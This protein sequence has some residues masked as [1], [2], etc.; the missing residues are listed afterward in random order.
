MQKNPRIIAQKLLNLYRQ[1]HVI[2]GGISA[3]NPIFIDEADDTVIEHLDALPGGRFLVAHIENL[4]SGKTP[5]DSIAPELIPYGG[6]MSTE[7]PSTQLS[8]ADIDELRKALGSFTPDQDGLDKI[9]E[10]NA[11]KKFGI[12]WMAGIKS[13]LADDIDL[14]NKW[15]TVTTTQRAYELWKIAS[16]MI[17]APMSERTRAEIQAELPE[18]ETYL[19]M[20][21]DSGRTLLTHL[22]EVVSV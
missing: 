4:R 6:M 8:D 10:L 18:F 11:V 19:P 5:M 13:A 22:R 3:L 15:N 21:G 7:I 1:S 17:S 9:T 20:F 12:E 14:Q 16:D 2:I